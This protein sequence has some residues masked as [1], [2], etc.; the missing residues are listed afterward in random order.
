M[1]RCRTVPGESLGSPPTR[2]LGSGIGAG[3]SGFT[4]L[5]DESLH[6]AQPATNAPNKISRPRSIVV[7]SKTKDW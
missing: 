7:G 2:T 4:I 1:G 6:P 3:F 5:G